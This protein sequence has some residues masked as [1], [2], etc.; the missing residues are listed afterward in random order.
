MR[1]YQVSHLFTFVRNVFLRENI[2]LIK[3]LIYFFV[4]VIEVWRD[5]HLSLQRTKLTRLRHFFMRNKLCHRLPGFS[6][7]YLLPILSFFYQFGEISFCLM[8]VE[9]LHDVMIS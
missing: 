3:E 8:N 2:T 6:N 9:D 1:V 7:N 5:P 4:F